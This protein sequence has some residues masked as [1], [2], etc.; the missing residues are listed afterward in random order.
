LYP[1]PV[2]LLMGHEYTELRHRIDESVNH[3]NKIFHGQLTTLYL[4][5][6]DLCILITDI[7][8]WC[9]GLATAAVAEIGYDGFG[10]PSF[11]KSAIP[12][13]AQRY[14]RTLHTLDDYALFVRTN[15]QR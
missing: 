1:V 12:N 14:R 4:S 5:R 10:R 11:H 8:R 7:R 13:L 9:A 15:M 2:E 6:D 3:R